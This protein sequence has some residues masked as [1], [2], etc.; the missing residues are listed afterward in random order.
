MNLKKVLSPEDIIISLEATSKEEVIKEMVDHLYK[1][2]KIEDREA[3]LQAILEREKKMSTGLEKGVALPH[4]KC[5]AVK[6][7]IAAIALKREGVDFDS[8]DGQP[9]QIFI[10]TL[11]PLNRSGPHIQFLAEVTR[12]LKSKEKREKILQASSKEEVLELF[13]S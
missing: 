3:A 9:A 10:M 6:E 2:G 11:S 1:R 8:I 12:L 4:G 7:L 13:C 5:E